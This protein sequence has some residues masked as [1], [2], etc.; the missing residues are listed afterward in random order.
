MKKFLVLSFILMLSVS[1][2]WSL[3]L[4]PLTCGVT[5][6]E[7]RPC[8]CF[9]YTGENG[10]IPGSESCEESDNDEAGGCERV[11]DCRSCGLNGGYTQSNFPYLNIG[12]I[13]EPGF[14]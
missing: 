5:P 4:N 1:T 12:P 7:P 10:K 8:Y 11:N 2:S 6:G 13:V 9:W 3:W 14:W